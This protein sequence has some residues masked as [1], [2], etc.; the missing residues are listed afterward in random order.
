MDTLSYDRPVTCRRGLLRFTQSFC[1]TP[2]GRRVHGSCRLSVSHRQRR[3]RTALVRSC[4]RPVSSAE[5]PP[6]ASMTPERMLASV[7]AGWA[8]LVRSVEAAVTDLPGVHPPLHARRPRLVPEAALLGRRRHADGPDRHRQP[9]GRRPHR[10]LQPAP[11]WRCRCRARLQTY[12]ASQQTSAISSP[13][14]WCA[15]WARCSPR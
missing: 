15:N 9:A 2:R 13:L 11:S 1:L 6:T 10:L 5:P 12:G 8:S 7:V 4:G 3:G 14:R